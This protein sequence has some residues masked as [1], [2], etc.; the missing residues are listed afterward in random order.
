MLDP[1]ESAPDDYGQQPAIR[2]DLLNAFVRFHLDFR[3]LEY[4]INFVK[5]ILAFYNALQCKI[6]YVRKS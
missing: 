1:A 6:R 2:L 5:I 4:F 3:D